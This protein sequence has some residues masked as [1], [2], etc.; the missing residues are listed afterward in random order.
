MQ[1][2]TWEIFYVLTV[3]LSLKIAQTKKIIEGPQTDNKFKVLRIY[4][5]FTKKNLFQA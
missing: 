3:K 2:N 5:H 4:S 1:K